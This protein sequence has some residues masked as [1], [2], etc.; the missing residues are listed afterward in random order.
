MAIVEFSFDANDVPVSAK[1]INKFVTKTSD[2][3]G[4][5]V[6]QVYWTWHTHVGL[7]LSRREIN[8]HDDSDFVM[9][10]WNDEKGEPETITYAST[11]GWSYP[12]YG[13]NVDATDAVK[14]KYAAWQANR[15]ENSKKDA[16]RQAAAALRDKRA[17][18]RKAAETHGFSFVL[19]SVRLRRLADGKI[20]EQLLTS[21]IRS[22]FKLGLRDQVVSWIKDPNP[23]YKT[24]LSRRQMECLYS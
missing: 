5:P 1:N 10:V 13:S 3:D 8:M 14:A 17:A 4:N 23:T 22:K 19:A 6:D 7:C 9:I 20:V 11:R 2:R 24:P 18:L 15:E 16:R 12:A 21:N